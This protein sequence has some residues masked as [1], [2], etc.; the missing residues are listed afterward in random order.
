MNPPR[1]YIFRFAEDGTELP[2][3]KLLEGIADPGTHEILSKLGSLKNKRIL[4][5]GPGA[6]SILRHLVDQI[7]HGSEVWAIDLDTRFLKDFNQPGLKLME[8]DIR[9]ADLPLGHFDLIHGRYFLQHIQEPS[10]LLAKFKSLLRPEGVLFLEEADMAA[11]RPIR[12][13]DE[14]RRESVRKV[15]AASQE[16]F[17]RRGVSKQMGA[18]LPGLLLSAGLGEVT[19]KSENHLDRGG[20]N[21]AQMMKLSMAQLGEQLLA[22]GLVTVQNLVHFSEATQDP[23]CWILH[24]AT[25]RAWGRVEG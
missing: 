15:F 24:F 21:L 6:G 3:L 4:E 16:N 11:A 14:A 2:R 10:A 7:P 8:G 13:E 23:E 17:R 25:C 9:T 22:T 20:S 18:E 12:I 19:W 5:L 1:D